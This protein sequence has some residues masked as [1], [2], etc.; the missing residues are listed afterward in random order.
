MK[1]YEVRQQEGSKQWGIYEVSTGTP[2]LVEGGF[3]SRLRA[4]HIMLSLR[5]EEK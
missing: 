4:F 3:F 5:S 1:I 2:I